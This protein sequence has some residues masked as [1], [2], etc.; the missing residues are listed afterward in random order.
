[1][2]DTYTLEFPITANTTAITD[3]APEV[4]V[5]CS[6][7]YALAVSMSVKPVSLLLASVM[8]ILCMFIHNNPG[9]KALMKL[10]MINA[11]MI[12]TMA[13]TWPVFSEGIITG[14]ITALRVNMIYIVFASLVFPLGM[15]KIYSAMYCLPEKLR[16]LIILTLRGIYILHDRLNTALISV[17][18]RAPALNGMMKLKVIAYIFASV[19]LQ[20]SDKSERMIIAAECRGGFAGFS[21]SEHNSLSRK[22]IAL[23]AVM[24]VYTLAVIAVNYA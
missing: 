16:I 3:T 11:I 1:M 5:L 6:V 20:A 15:A 2:R 14:I 7:L 18:L 13:L 10:N 24:S 12:I 8:P 21:Q 17:R 23:C 4:N 22:D 9:M 19:L